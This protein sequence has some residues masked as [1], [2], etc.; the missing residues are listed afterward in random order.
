MKRILAITAVV[1]ASIVGMQAGVDE[2]YSKVQFDDVLKNNEVVVA[3]FHATWCGPCKRLAP[4]YSAV[5]AEFAGRAKL[6]KIDVDKVKPLATKYSIRSMPT[7]I[8][9]RN[10]KRVDTSKGALSK[11]K[12]R[13]NIENLL[14]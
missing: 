3:D 7:L 5:A 9:F 10:G 14:N 11:A 4:T 2:I 13:Q 6:V 1:C 12:L 8:Y